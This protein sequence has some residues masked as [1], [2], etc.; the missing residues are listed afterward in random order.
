MYMLIGL[1]VSSFIIL[2]SGNPVECFEILDAM[3]YQAN[4]KYIS[5]NFPEHVMIYFESSEIVTIIPIFEKLKILELYQVFIGQVYVPAFGK[6]LFYNINSDLITNLSSLIVQIGMA[7][8]LFL[9]SKMYLK[10][11]FNI[12]YTKIRT[13]IYCNKMLCITQQIAFLV[14]KINR[15]SLGIN[16]MM[17]L[18]GVVYIIKANCWDLLFKTML[19]L[20]S[21]KENNLRNQI[22][23]ILA[24][25][26]LVSVLVLVFYIFKIK[27]SQM[28]LKKR[29]SLCYDG[30]N[31]AKKI[32]FVLVL[33]G[34]QKSQLLQ[35]I[36]LSLINSIYLTIIVLGKMVNSKIDLIIILMF[37]IPV[38]IFTL[39]N[40]CHEETYSHFLSLQSQVM[41]GFGQIGLLSF[42]IMAPLIK[43]GHQIKSKLTILIKRWKK[44]KVN[45]KEQ[46]QSSLFI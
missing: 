38:I 22:Q 25:S 39:L 42:G 17:S 21:E 27:D 45:Q 10:I 40:I 9:I 43:Y 3:Q 6:F 41:V 1:G 11:V 44:Y 23:D 12:Q 37:E 33:I 7:G 28:A 14:H 30:L 29:K 15:L 24:Q 2:L 26:L 8:V 20:Y 13:F 31:V 4:L 34:C 32:L 16:Q 46:A 18:Q 19:Y 5:S 36:L 35:S